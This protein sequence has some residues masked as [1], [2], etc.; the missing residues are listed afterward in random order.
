MSR[1]RVLLHRLALALHKTV[2]ELELT[3]TPRELRD[4]L[5][6]EATVSALPDKLADDHNALL[7]SVVV[8]LVRPGEAMAARPSDF[9]CIRERAQPQPAPIDDGLSEAERARA[10]YYG[11]G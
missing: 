9:Y 2:G 8:N 5:I 3:M 1:E 6:Y 4:W 10:I 11:G 7:C